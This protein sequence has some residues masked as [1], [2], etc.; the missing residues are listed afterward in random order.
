MTYVEEV[1]ADITWQ[2]RAILID[3]LNEGMLQTGKYFLSWAEHV[4][5]ATWDTVRVVC[6]KRPGVTIKRV[7]THVGL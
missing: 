5:G 3:W 4:Q 7:L 1:Q 2:M 6:T